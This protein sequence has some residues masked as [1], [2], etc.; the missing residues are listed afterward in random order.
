MK[1]INEVIEDIQEAQINAGGNFIRASEIKKM[2]IIEL[3][4]LLIPNN[5]LFEIKHMQL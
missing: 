2:T 4:E 5:V 1:D 3:L